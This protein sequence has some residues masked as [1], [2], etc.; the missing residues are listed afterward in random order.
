MSVT[1]R[2]LGPFEVL[3]DGEPIQLGTRQRAVLSA[4]LLNANRTLTPGRLVDLVW[5]RPAA[6]PRSNLRTYI[7]ALRDR[8]PGGASRIATHPSGY[9][10]R[11]ERDE[12]DIS[13][14]SDY[15]Q[16]G[17]AALSEESPERG[18]AWL[19]RAL[20]LWRG[21]ALEGVELT[22][23]L[24]AEAVALD[25]ARLAVWEQYVDTRLRRGGAAAL[26]AS[27]RRLVEEHPLR[28]SLWRR[29][30][31]V[32]HQAGRKAEA[33]AAYEALRLRLEE[34]LGCAPSPYTRDLMRRISVDELPLPS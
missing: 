7:A 4:F 25:D 26:V 20:R 8:L 13:L 29:Y 21:R 15:A 12:V 27:V 14:F 22:P 32:L 6:S 9:V 23:A 33:L 16:R 1:F 17:S 19:E 11:A 10:L 18:A 30:L 24:Q 28:E 31:L 34:E 5:D 3:A 2:V